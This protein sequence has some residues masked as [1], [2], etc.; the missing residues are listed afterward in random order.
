MKFQTFDQNG[1]KKGHQKDLSP[2]RIPW[3]LIYYRAHFSAPE[4]VQKAFVAIIVEG[5]TMK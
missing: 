1:Y 2:T 5:Q 3:L 4:T